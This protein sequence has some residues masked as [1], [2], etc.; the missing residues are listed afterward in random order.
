MSARRSS[1]PGPAA[2]QRLTLACILIAIGALF[3]PALMVTMP[4]LLDYPNHYA[5][6]WLLAGGIDAP[7]LTSIYAVDWA[8]ATT[9]IGIDLLAASVGK[10]IGIDRLGPLLVAL[11]SALPVI[12]AVLLHRRLFGQWTWWQ[13]GFAMA[14]WGMTVLAGFLNFQIG[15]GLALLAAVADLQLAQSSR[16]ATVVFR[17]AASAALLVVHPFA[18]LFYAVLAA[19]L[20]LGPEI[21]PLLSWRGAVAAAARVLLAA[22]PIAA[23]VLLFVLFAPNMPTQGEE[24][25]GVIW[26]KFSPAYAIEVL[27]G[28]VRT[29][30]PLLD[31]PLLMV[32]ALAIPL[33]GR[34][35]RLQAHGGLTLAA[36][37]LALVSL[38]MPEQIGDTAWMNLRLPVMALLTFLVSVN[39]LAVTRRE[40][41]IAAC[42]LLVVTLSRTAGVG[43]VWVMRQPDIAALQRVLA[44]VPAGAAVLPVT[45]LPPDQLLRRHVGRFTYGGP[46]HT[47]YATLVI[48][49][50][51]AFTPILFTTPGKQPVQPRPPWDEISGTEQGPLLP[52]ELNGQLPPPAYAREWR[53]RFDYVLLLNADMPHRTVAQPPADLELVGDEGFARLYR[54]P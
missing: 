53:A 30:D 13:V 26:P 3:A 38:A 17:V 15:L 50:R 41:A 45:T 2:A 4:P 20:A 18:S 29:Y 16:T 6:L 36:A 33:A 52:E 10:L 7:P 5:R 8:F 21:R 24:T 43:G 19:A 39:P 12:G 40:A 42:G 44:H 28:G 31:L 35:K 27:L 11:S 49:W 46:S 32:L 51:Q 54:V 1:P 14:G 23:P 9:N 47:H 34:L 22:A 37:G 25:A 48:P